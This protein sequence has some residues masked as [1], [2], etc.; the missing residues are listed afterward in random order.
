MIYII[1]SLTMGR[2]ITLDVI[3]KLALSK[4]VLSSPYHH[5]YI[6]SYHT[7]N[8][9]ISYDI[10]NKE[11]INTMQS[12]LSSW[13]ADSYSGLELAFWMITLLCSAVRSNPIFDSIFFSLAQAVMTPVVIS[14]GTSL[15][16]TPRTRLSCSCS[17]CCCVTE[18]STANT[19]SMG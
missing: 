7:M 9:I 1:L 16:L 12:S 19:L 18:K 4:S 2:R 17:Y 6:K 8:N 11:I 13:P 14:S 5:D 15:I 3:C 10:M